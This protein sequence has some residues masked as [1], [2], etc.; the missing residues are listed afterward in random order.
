M[1][2][3]ERWTIVT[4]QRGHRRNEVEQLAA[5]PDVWTVAMPDEHEP[6]LCDLCNRRIDPN[7][8]VATMGSMAVCTQCRASVDARHGP[9]TAEP[10]TCTGC[11]P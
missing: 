4:D 11:M 10:C 8:D 9:L 5:M 6:W 7:S 1:T 2:T 3:T